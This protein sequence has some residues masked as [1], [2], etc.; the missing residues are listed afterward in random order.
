ML[1]DKQGKPVHFPE[2]PN[3]FEFDGEVARIF[4]DMASRA[5]PNYHTAHHYHV[6]IARDVLSRPGARVLD[7]G[8]SRGAFYRHILDQGL[9][10]NY[11]AVDSSQS[12]CE[13][14]AAD[15]PDASVQVADLTDPS[16]QHSLLRE[17][18]FD[19]VCCNYVLQ[20]I[21]V[22]EQFKVLS[23][24][25]DLVAP[26]GFLFVGHKTMHYGA[27]GAAAH[28]CYIDFRIENGYSREE[29]EAKTKALRG[30]MFPMTNESVVNYIKVRFSEVQ[31]TTRFMM[32]STLAARK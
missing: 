19:V 23:A 25:C 6:R 8:A 29:I 13:M 1:T 17:G 10:P 12:M 11:L 24:L 16:V 20:F 14:L 30:S 32:F 5:I 26:G 7:V 15:F 27:L 2:N 31:E 28:E 9:S 18:P 22:S 21:R 4:P 3:A